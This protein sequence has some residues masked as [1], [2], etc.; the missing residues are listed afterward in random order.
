MEEQQDNKNFEE[1]TKHEKKHLKK[2]Q[3]EEEQKQ[4]EEKK[5]K[6]ELKSKTTKYVI[7]AAVILLIVFGGYY[8]IIKPI[9][10]FKPY[11]SGFYHWHANFEAS[12]CGEPA[13]VRCGAGMCGPMNMHHHNDNIIH[14]EGNTIAKQQDL[15]L[16]NFFHGLGLDFSNQSLL[17]KKN[18]DLCPNGKLGTVNMYVNGQQN[19]EFDKYMLKRCDSS[20]IKEDC[21]KI[22]LRFE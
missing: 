14:I 12:I 8:F 20:N 3:R 1:L 21:E 2:E 19:Y 13:Q 15:Q 11:Y 16:G 22:D 7:T 4:H 10:S 17:G 18:G 6:K 5:S 9:T